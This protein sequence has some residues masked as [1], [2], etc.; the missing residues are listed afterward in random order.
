MWAIKTGRNLCCCQSANAAVVVSAKSNDIVR[1]FIC[2]YFLT[3]GLGVAIIHH[4]L[5]IM[6][7]Q[8]L[9]KPVAPIK[10]II[11]QKNFFARYNF[12]F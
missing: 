7:S 10:Y 2:V 5:Y 12:D 6:V 9:S 8:R 3:E 4:M 11:A 1:F